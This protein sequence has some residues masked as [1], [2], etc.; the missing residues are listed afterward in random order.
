MMTAGR[1]YGVRVIG[2]RIIRALAPPPMLED[3][4][5]TVG[6]VD[7]PVRNYPRPGAVPLVALTRA[8]RNS[9]LE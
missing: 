1:D 8:I 7:L 9:G 3:G 4:K 5:L 2:A 6:R